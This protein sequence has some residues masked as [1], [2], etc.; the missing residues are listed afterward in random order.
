MTTT[1]ET[2]HCW[3]DGSYLGVTVLTRLVWFNLKVWMLLETYASHIKGRAQRQE[4]MS[5]EELLRSFHELQK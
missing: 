5:T 3:V 2:A 4:M 1:A